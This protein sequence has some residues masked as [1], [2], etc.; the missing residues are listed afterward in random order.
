[1]TRQKMK[2]SQGQSKGHPYMAVEV[3]VNQYIKS[4]LISVKR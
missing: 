4:A 3:K 1:M 2:I